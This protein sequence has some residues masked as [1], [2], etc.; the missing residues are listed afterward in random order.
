MRRK[1]QPVITLI[2]RK[3]EMSNL[4]KVLQVMKDKALL[5]DFL[6]NFR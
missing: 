1:K 4:V 5:I 6:Q 3:K 2:P